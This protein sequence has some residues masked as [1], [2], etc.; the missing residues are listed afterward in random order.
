MTK[1]DKFEKNRYRLLQQLVAEAQT[2]N[3][4]KQRQLI[5]SQIVVMILRSRPLCRRFHGT[6][7]TGVYQEIYDLVKRKMLTQI[8]DE[9]TKIRG[10][11]N[12]Q[13]EYLYT[14][15]TQTFKQILS[16]EYLKKLGLTAQKYRPNSDLRTYALT[17][18]IKAIK[19][20]GKLCR[21]HLNKF[22]PQLY[23]TLYEEALA[24]TFTYICLKIEDYDPERGS[25]KFMNW[26]NFNL[27]KFLLKCYSQYHKYLEYNL[28]LLGDLEQIGY[29][30]DDGYQTND[31]SELLYQYILQDPNLLFEDTYIRNYPQASFKNIALA[32][33]AGKNWSGIAEDLQ[34]PISTI[35][36]F[37]NRWC[38]RFAPLIESELKKHL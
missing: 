26:V 30:T 12:L 19:L 32:K 31:I 5:V 28:P 38:R 21:P 15:Q 4:L 10:A 9:L 2:S 3:S 25:K 22:S 29:P 11:K 1:I 27:D 16:D 17:E 8:E 20:S 23:Q 14:M 7:L 24:E 33:F 34:L 35:S 37:Y 6:P 18:L 36:G 13:P